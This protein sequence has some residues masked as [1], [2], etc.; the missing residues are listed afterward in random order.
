MVV[1]FFFLHVARVPVPGTEND[2]VMTRVRRLDL[3]GVVIFLPAIVC[4][5]LALQWGGADY[6]WNSSRIIG[7]F[8]G[9]GVMLLVFIGIQFWRGD[10]GTLPPRLFRD[11]NLPFAMLFSFFFGAGFFILIYYLSLYFQAVQGVSAVQAGIKI[12]PLLLSCVLTSVVGGA[13]IGAVGYYNAVAIP[14]LAMF[15]IGAGLITTFDVDTPMRSWFGYQVLTGLG[16]GPAFQIPVLVVQTVMTP[17]WVPVGTAAAQFFQALGGAIFVAVAQTVFQTNL[18]KN[19]AAHT[20]GLDPVLFINIGASE[21]RE[22]L[23]DMGRSDAAPAVI[24]AYMSGLRGTYWIAMGTAVAAFVSS[25]GLQW[26]SVKKNASSG[27]AIHV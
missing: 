5:V 26:K 7:L 25:L 4:L 18:I 1:V 3:L 16:L 11:R 20:T 14:G 24:D 21:V 10:E 19:V 27:P 17:E 22:V 12:L 13:L 15:A 23:A 2:S 8:V 9:F 6:P